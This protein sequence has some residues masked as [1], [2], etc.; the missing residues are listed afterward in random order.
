MAGWSRR[1][2]LASLIALAGASYRGGIAA[3]AATAPGARK[4]SGG[5]RGGAEAVGPAVDAATVFAPYLWAQF[6]LAADDAHAAAKRGIEVVSYQQADFNGGGGPQQGRAAAADW[7]RKMDA[8]GLKKILM[9]GLQSVPGDFTSTLKRDLLDPNVIGFTVEDEPETPSGPG[10][11]ARRSSAG[12]NELFDQWEA[13][14]AALG[15]SYAKRYGEIFKMVNVTYNVLFVAAHPSEEVYRKY[16]DIDRVDVWSCDDYWT[17]HPR[18]RLAG[19][20]DW[21][22][23]FTST[24]QGLVADLTVTGPMTTHEKNPATNLEIPGTRRVAPTKARGKR[25][26]TYLLG[27]SSNGSDRPWTPA[28]ASTVGWSGIIHGNSGTNWFATRFKP[29][30]A[31]DG[32]RD[33]QR[34]VPFFREFK[35]RVEML[36]T[37]GVLMEPQAAGSGRAPWV[38]RVSAPANGEPKDVGA[39]WFPA[40]GAQ[41]QGGFEGVEM[42]TPDR[43]KAVRVVHNL[44]LEPLVLNDA[45]WGI[46]GVTF[47][48]GEVQALLAGGAF[49]NLFA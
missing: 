13:A 4:D 44:T 6:N 17:Q 12:I 19:R 14:A 28:E 34:L 9:P 21:G 22:Q 48:P 23:P 40:K 45:A 31:T 42:F 25:A 32:M 38:K 46:A 15:P 36:R 16:L 27:C 43:T 18:S 47:G 37:M 35:R 3:R 49:R 8:A 5:I 24:W 41:L 2:T 1:H 29:T 26:I 39:R 20:G 33:D 10:G 7:H 30:F 11:V